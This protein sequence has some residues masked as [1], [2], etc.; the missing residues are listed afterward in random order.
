MAR[1]FA[2][3]QDGIL[4][5]LSSEALQEL[6]RSGPVRRFSEGAI[7]FLEG[8][9]G[10]S[11]YVLLSGSLRLFRTDGEGREIVLHLVRPGELFAA[12]A[13]SA[14]PC[15]AIRQTLHLQNRALQ[16]GGSCR[17]RNPT[18][19]A[20]PGTPAHGRG[21]AS[22]LEGFRAPDLAASVGKSR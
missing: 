8:Q 17:N 7:L 6:R 4:G 22:G 18:G 11:V 16:A 21:R 12:T 3:A 15:R 14:L 20:F 10:S 19:D 2:T 1:D 13:L 9:A 5:S